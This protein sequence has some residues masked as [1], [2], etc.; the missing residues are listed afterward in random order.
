MLK[1]QILENVLMLKLPYLWKMG[2]FR[3]QIRQVKLM[4]G[5]VVVSKLSCVPYCLHQKGMILKM[6]IINGQLTV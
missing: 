5:I 2:L 4:V 1:K 6:D 3:T